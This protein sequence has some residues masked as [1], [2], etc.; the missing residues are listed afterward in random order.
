MQTATTSA[1]HAAK[2][3]VETSTPPAL[4]KAAEEFESIFLSQ[5]L[6]GLT[7]GLSSGLQGGD[8][9]DPF[10]QMLQDEYAKIVSRSGGVGV[11]DAV[12]REMLKVQEQPA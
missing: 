12:L 8:K 4:R 7:A 2:T 10:S 5:V 1:P 11:A 6:N 3:V 9:D